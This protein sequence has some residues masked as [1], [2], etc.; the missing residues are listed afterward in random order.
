MSDLESRIAET[1]AQK[2]ADWRKAN[3]ST[4]ITESILLEILGLETLSGSNLNSSNLSGSNLSGVNLSGSNA[5]WA[6]FT[7]SNLSGSNLSG[8]NFSGSTFYCSNLS[9]T[10]LRGSKLSWADFTGSNLSR[11]NLSLTNLTET[12]L[13]EVNSSGATIP[14]YIPL[15]T[16]SGEGDIR[17]TPDGWR[18]S[19]G[20]WQHRTLSELQ[21]IIAD[22]VDW[23]E[24]RGDE[25]EK[26]RPFLVAVAALMEAQIAYY[27]NLIAELEEKWKRS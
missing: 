24:A 6:D 1:N 21:L 26:R 27:P 23:P 18:V 8:S 5:L 16:P 7:G 12:N 10:Y 15:K 9:G 19:L 4:Q 11:S 3:P 17:A 25:R 2:I 14:G 13:R 20:C 22:K